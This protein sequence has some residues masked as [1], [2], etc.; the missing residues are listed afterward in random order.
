M[1]KSVLVCLLLATPG[2]AAAS[3]SRTVAADF[4]I[5][6]KQE[7]LAGLRRRAAAGQLPGKVDLR[8]DD[9]RFL[10]LGDVALLT[11]IDHYG[12]GREY[13]CS[14]VWVR[15]GEGWRVAHLHFSLLAKKP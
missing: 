12:D 3:A 1:T 14:E 13:E 9:R 15:G 2:L 5:E 8:S 7:Q 6:T 10:F 11:Q 4:G